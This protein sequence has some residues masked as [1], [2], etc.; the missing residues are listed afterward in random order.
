MIDKIPRSKKLFKEKIDW[1][2]LKQFKN[3]IVI[4]VTK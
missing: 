2:K 4:H 3:K 1:N